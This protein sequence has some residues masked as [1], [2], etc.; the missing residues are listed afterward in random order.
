[1]VSV[2]RIAAGDTDAYRHLRLLAAEDAPTAFGKDKQALLETPPEDWEAVVSA[3]ASGNLSAIFVAEADGGLIGC[4][5]ASSPALDPREQLGAMWVAPHHRGTGAAAKLASAAIDWLTSTGVSTIRLSVTE[6]NAPAR[7]LYERLG[8]RT[9]GE[10][11]PLDS[12]PR[13][14]VEYMALH[15]GKASG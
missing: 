2:R 4:V 3:G 7:R 8:F 11:E 6:G 10:Q 1:M 13:L 5:S 9:T 14:N 12:D 15:N